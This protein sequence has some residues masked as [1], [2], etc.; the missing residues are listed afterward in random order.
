M[1]HACDESDLRHQQRPAP[2]PKSP[3][4]LPPPAPTNPLA[5]LGPPPFGRIQPTGIPPPTALPSPVKKPAPS[6]NGKLQAVAAFAKKPAGKAGAGK[7]PPVRHLSIRFRRLD[8][9]LLH[10]VAADLKWNG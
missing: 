7:K 3:E 9:S 10:F 6:K 4:P 8:P 1:G 2:V 5:F